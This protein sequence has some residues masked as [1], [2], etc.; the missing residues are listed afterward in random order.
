MM[1]HRL[2]IKNFKKWRDVT[3]DLHDNVS[4]I[5]GGNNSGKSSVL[6]ALAIWEF[7]KQVLIYEKGDKAIQQNFRKAGCGITIEDF[8]PINIPSFK[9]L[10]TNLNPNGGRY[11]LEICC[12]WMQSETEKF[13]KIGFACVQEKLYIKKVA[14]N[15]QEGD[16]CPRIAYLPTFAGIKTKEEWHTP[17][18]RN[19]YIGQGLAGSILRNQIMDL[20]RVNQNLRKA[21]QGHNRR[22]PKAELEWILANDPYEILNSVVY[23]IFKG[24][25]YPKKFDPNFNSYVLINFRKGEFRGRRFI[26]YQGHKERDIM[27]EGSG[28]LQWLSVYTMAVTPEIDILL[29]DEPDAHLHC[30]LQTELFDSLNSIASRKKKQVL[31]ATHS[32][33][34]IKSYDYN[35]ILAAKTVSVS[36]LKSEAAKTKVIA[37]IGSEYFPL[38]ESVQTYKR[39]LFVENKSDAQILKILCDKYSSWPNNLVVWPRANKNKERAALFNYIKDEIDGLKCLSLRDRDNESYVSGRVDLHDNVADLIEGNKELRYRKWR[40]HE[41]E[42]YLISKPTIIRLI[43]QKRE[44]DEAEALRLFAEETGRLGI[45]INADYKQSERTQSNASIYDLEAKMLLDPICDEF[46][47]D[48]YEIAKEMSAE[49]IFDDVR[50]LIDELVAMCRH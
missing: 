48:K 37:G 24:S 47:I 17:A 33:D 27:V 43:M 41:I 4:L 32:V 6:H 18:I 50:T 22:L 7:A 49:E 1:I 23:G 29:L 12:Y 5:V 10:W 3:I 26:P 35:K 28:F 19:L 34:V 42:S 13:L 25:L 20:Y 16:R 8:T 15:L 9:Y 11:S 36:Y 14:S 21:R 38:L 31:I 30:S 40:R 2:Q 46:K 45:V 39:V 44:V